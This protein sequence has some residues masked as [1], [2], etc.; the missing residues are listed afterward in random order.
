MIPMSWMKSKSKKTTPELLDPVLVDDEKVK[1]FDWY[2]PEREKGI[3]FLMG[4]EPVILSLM[5]F[6][7][8]ISEPLVEIRQ[9]FGNPIAYRNDS[10]LT[11]LLWLAKQYTGRNNIPWEINF[12]WNVCDISVFLLPWTVSSMEVSTVNVPMLVKEAFYDYVDAQSNTRK[13]L[14]S[15]YTKN[16]SSINKI[17]K[18][19]ME[20]L[21]KSSLFFDCYA[22]LNKNIELD[23][24][25]F[26][27]LKIKHNACLKPFFESRN[28]TEIEKE[29]AYSHLHRWHQVHT[30]R[31][32]SVKELKD[33]LDFMFPDSA[34]F[35]PNIIPSTVTNLPRLPSVQTAKDYLLGKTTSINTDLYSSNSMTVNILPDPL[36][37]TPIIN[38]ENEKA[39]LEIIGQLSQPLSLIPARSDVAKLLLQE[40][41]WAENVCKEIDDKI[42]LAKYIGQDY[43]KLPPILLLGQPGCGKTRFSK[44]L[45]ELA[46]IHSLV[47]SGGGIDGASMF[48]GSERKWST[49]DTGSLLKSMAKWKQA[50]PLFILDEIDKASTDE[51]YTSL[52]DALLPFLESSTANAILDNFLMTTV[53]YSYCNWIATAN[54][55]SALPTPLLSRFLVLKMDKPSR[56][57]TEVIVNQTRIDMA[58]QY[59]IDVSRIPELDDLDIERLKPK[60]I[61]R[62][63]A[64]EIRVACEKALADKARN[65]QRK[66]SLVRNSP[67]RNN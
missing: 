51:R 34:S 61:E 2:H 24:E 35:D 44:R 50:N 47:L 25:D 13:I 58:K 38:I 39:R 37:S 60:T 1:H 53:D 45:A 64:R 7:N 54:D 67:T 40:F 29:D 59:N 56:E 3:S 32:T 31:H 48:N 9:N 22:D 57:H 14:F 20:R 10:R 18:P 11:T 65:G 30:I 15:K 12:L 21:L 23:L 16:Q 33:C 55:V 6:I 28:F 17:N 36:G 63:S 62:F 4:H 26:L 27:S 46:G 43:M 41:P 49:A 66:L 8:N 52:H 19:E 42:V 5:A